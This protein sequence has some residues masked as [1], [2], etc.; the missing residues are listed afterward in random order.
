MP[1]YKTGTVS[2]VQNSNAVIGTGTAFIANSRVGDG[3]RG[4]D[5]GWYEV[6]N[7]ASDTAMSI[8]P[9]Y[10]G[11]TNAAGIYALAPMQGYVKD[12]ADTL[13]SF[14]N[15]YGQKLAALGST[16][17]YEVLPVN[18]G[19]TGGNTPA[20]ARDGLELVKMTSKTDSTPGRV[21][22]VDGFGLGAPVIVSGVNVDTMQSFGYYYVTGA[23]MTPYSNGWLLV[24]PVSTAYCAQSFI[25]ESDGKRYTRT[26]R[27]TWD[28]WLYAAP[29][30]GTVSQAGGAVTGAIVE[31]GSNVNGDF[32]KFADGTMI[33]TRNFS[34]AS[35]VISSPAGGVY[36][37]GLN[38][39]AFPATFAVSAAIPVVNMS[40]ISSG[41][42]AW[43][44][45]G[46]GLPTSTATQYFCLIVPSAGTYNFTVQ[47][48]AI[49]RWF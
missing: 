27:T 7:I 46:S 30:V 33:C 1:W 21:L 8:S 11:V 16:A 34:W 36:Y 25:S 49:G 38:G 24:Q 3:F 44:A 10:Q 19:G 20:L 29:A 14:V 13:R 26:K 9:N 48:T 35:L 28:P 31:R 2:V 23:T 45:M 4:P 12:S 17:N 43:A 39:V 40:V 22:T 37:L 47:I 5:G 15:T 41:G 6:T 42:L 32:T 18:K